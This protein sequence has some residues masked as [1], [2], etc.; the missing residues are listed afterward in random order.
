MKKTHMRLSDG[1]ELIY[2]D[3]SDSTTR[4]VTDPRRLATA[5][6]VPVLRYDAALD[7]WVVMA[8]HRQDRTYL[9]PDDECPLCPSA[10]GR[11]TE[12]P[13]SD[14][15]VVVFENRFPTLAYPPAAAA[16][17]PAAAEAD[18]KAGQ[19]VGGEAGAGADGKA[20][21]GVGGEAGAGAGQ[22]GQLG[23]SALY[24]EFPA[25]GRCEV[26]CYTSDHNASL[27][28]LQ[29]SRMRTV[30]EAWVDRTIALSALPH[31]EQ[32]FCFENYG[33]QIGV[34][35][36]HPHGQIYAYPFVTPR[37]RRMMT[38]A[39]RYRER[40][41]RNIFA[42]LLA[43]EVRCGERIV[44]RSG[45]WT[46]FV[47]FAARWPLEVHLYPN[48]HVM[49]LPD[50][51]E[52]E[53]DDFCHIYL[54]V[55]RRMA[56]LYE[57]PIPYIS[58]WHQAPVRIDRELGYLHLQIHSAQRAPGKLKYLAGSEAAMG[59]FINDVLPEDAARALR[60]ARA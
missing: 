30:L 55:M 3:E 53:R 22:A 60:E 16:P 33:R 15:D 42:D 52:A 17:P 39:R 27:A 31:V 24:T 37:T 29:P 2:F 26:V 35:L 21:Q 58:A 25:V 11:H 8:G 49:G 51:S 48:R 6:I 9:P 45:H 23:T 12:I 7:E 44:V 46:G 38:A 19:G 57:S 36:G 10:E 32:V 28:A 47:P 20:G 56:S 40:T 14:Y 50:L 43:E 54:D 13:S 18:G 41:W 34:T 4:N 59:T 1:R 5:P